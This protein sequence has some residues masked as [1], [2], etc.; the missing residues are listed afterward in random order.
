M[1]IKYNLTKYDTLAEEFHELAQKRD[2][3]F[4]KDEEI[5]RAMAIIIA[6]FSPALSWQTY[7][8][9]SDGNP[10]LICSCQELKDECILAKSERWKRVLPQHIQEVARMNIKDNLFY[11]W[12]SSNSQNCPK[13]I[14]RNAWA[15]LQHSFNEECDG[16]SI[17][18]H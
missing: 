12:L 8:I 16:I 4:N 2:T 5:S 14:Y 18:Q 6:S 11:T 10:N 9:I 3:T 13:D 1:P 7:K 17:K 15:K